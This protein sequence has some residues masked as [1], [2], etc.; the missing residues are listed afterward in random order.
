MKSPY[1]LYSFHSGLFPL[2]IGISISMVVICAT[3]LCGCKDNNTVA[4]VKVISLN[5]MKSSGEDFSFTMDGEIYHFMPYPFN[6]SE[7]T[8]N[9]KDYEVLIMGKQM[10]SGTS[11]SVLPI[12]EMVLEDQKE[13]ETYVLLT[14]PYEKDLRIFDVEDLFELT[15]K[16]FSVKQIVEYWYANRK[17]LTGTTVK[18]WEN[19]S[20][21]DFSL[22]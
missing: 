12:A 3:F 7:L 9:G 19:R 22:E 8:L 13:S 18:S 20:I 17:G 1:I 6:F 4:E 5:V 11:V 15:T 2:V 14:I 21:Q 16:Q 10:K